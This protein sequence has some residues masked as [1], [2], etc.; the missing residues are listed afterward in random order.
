MNII[1]EQLASI[2][3]EQN[4]KRVF[5]KCENE[6]YFVV[7]SI[8]EYT[9]TLEQWTGLSFVDTDINDIERNVKSEIDEARLNLLAYPIE[10]NI[11]MLCKC[12]EKNKY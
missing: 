3:G 1:T 10:D 4:M 11:K 7:K 8:Q 9:N 6:F 5:P 12:L 2:R